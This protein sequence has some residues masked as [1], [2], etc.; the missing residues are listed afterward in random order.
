MPE[1]K[2]NIKIIHADSIK[3]LDGIKDKE[4][5]LI[6]TSPPYLDAEVDG[7]Y[8]DFLQKFLKNACRI[9]QTVVMFNSSRRMIE[10]CQKFPPKCILIWH[11]P[12][13]LPA[14][15]YEPI[16]VYTEDKVWGRGRIYRD[17]LSYNGVRNKNKLHI[18]ENPVE[19]YVEILKF[20]PSAQKVL[21]PFAGSGTTGIAC[22]KMLRQCM[23]IEFLP[24]NI[25]II[26][27]RIDKY[28]K[29]NNR[30]D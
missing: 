6:L 22:L 21:D 4:F 17:V 8:Y 29:E 14:Y 24:E 20:F 7:A 9:A 11:K 15:K 16:F 1:S 13:T 12:F 10:I 30:C 23:M 5:D 18:N 26:N 19:L 25:K 27:E 3:Y 2:E 28:V